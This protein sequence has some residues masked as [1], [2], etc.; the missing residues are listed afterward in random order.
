[1]QLVLRSVHTT[2]EKLENAAL[3]LRQ[4]LPS[5]L[6]CHENEDFNFENALQTAGI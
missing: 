3:F 2:L 5:T 4:G 6:V 1:M